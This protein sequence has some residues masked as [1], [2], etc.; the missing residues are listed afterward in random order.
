LPIQRCQALL[1]T[2]IL[3]GQVAVLLRQLGAVRLGLTQLVLKFC[4][5]SQRGGVPLLGDQ[6]Q[7]RYR[8][9]KQ[10]SDCG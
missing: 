6:R 9:R 10:Q 2:L 8:Y 7:C 5:L 4:F 1:K 3:R